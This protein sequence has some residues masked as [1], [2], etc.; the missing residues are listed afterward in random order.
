MKALKFF[1]N[2]SFLIILILLITGGFFYNSQNLKLELSQID[3]FGALIILTAITNKFNFSNFI[4]NFFNKI[5]NFFNKKPFFSLSI[6]FITYFILMFVIQI[7]RYE[8]YHAN[9]L[10]LSYVNQSI[11]CTLFCNEKFLYSSI[12]VNNTYLGEHFSP[13]LAFISPLYFL[14]SSIYLLFFVQ[15]FLI[16]L[17][18]FLIYKISKLYNL[19]TLSSI[20]I[21]LCYFLYQ[22]VRNANTFDLREDNFFIPLGLALF[23]FFKKEKF[24][25]FWI[26]SI[27]IFLVKENAS[28]LTLLF[29]VLFFFKHSNNKKLKLHSISLFIISL[30]VFIIVN[31]KLTPYFSLSTNKTRLAFRLQEQGLNLENLTLSQYILKEPK[32]FFYYL[33]SRQFSKDAIKYFLIIF[34]PFLFF[35]KNNFFILFLA[36]ILYYLNLFI[37]VQTIGF[38]YEC[39][40]V[41]FLFL[42]L[43]EG[44]TKQNPNQE[45][46]NKKLIFLIFTFFIFFGRSPVLLIRN[47][48]PTKHHLNLSQALK[49]IPNNAKV[50]AMGSIHPHLSN[51]KDILFL[52]PNIDVDYVVMSLN[53]EMDR[54]ASPN[55]E[56]TIQKYID[57]KKYTKLNFNDP[58]VIILKKNIHM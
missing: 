7:L 53:K 22:P 38:H 51:R 40:M 17:G 11:F 30:I 6:I 28:L 25:L 24:F 26:T 27:L 47:Y 3:A 33:I 5:F 44:V 54:Y 55:L 14:I 34:T 13:I 32:E 10:D 16:T 46:L 58:E 43:I 21:V 12:S 15:T 56:E 29:S 2:L 35:I 50:A 36:Y 42:G 37:G 19:S 20:V 49:Q 57:S 52:D 18:G 23:Y 39:I 31:A 9:A 41:P 8:S 45:I 48:I 1:Q 4:T